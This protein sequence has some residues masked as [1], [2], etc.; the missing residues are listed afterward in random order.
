MA[1]TQGV[2]QSLVDKF[3]KKEL[4]TSLGHETTEPTDEAAN[5]SSEPEEEEP[6]RRGTTLQ[7]DLGVSHA[8]RVFTCVP[9]SVSIAT[10]RDAKMPRRYV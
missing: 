2:S 9:Y 6:R 1:V 10:G 3:L 8:R 4:C 7:E 5:C